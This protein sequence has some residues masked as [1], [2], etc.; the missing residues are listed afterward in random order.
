MYRRLAA[1]Q[2]LSVDPGK[3]ARPEASEGMIRPPSLSKTFDLHFSGDPAFEQPPPKEDEKARKTYSAKLTAA[4]DTGDWSPLLVADGRPSKFVMQ[5]IHRP[6]WRHVIDRASLSPDNPR[7]LGPNVVMSIA[8]RMAIQSVPDLGIE[9]KHV[10]DTG[11][12]GW[13]MAPESV[14]DTLDQISPAI[15]GEL[16]MVLLDKLNED[17]ISP[18]S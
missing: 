14:V 12:D 11:F 3:D 7:H 18:K 2:R 1:V 6:T 9:C 8:F 13:K 4:R 10:P 5:Q 17:G 16:G 15:V